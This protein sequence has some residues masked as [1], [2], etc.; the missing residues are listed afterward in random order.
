MFEGDPG[1]TMYEFIDGLRYTYYCAQDSGCDA[2]YWNSLDT[3]DALPTVNPYTVD[4][5]TISIDLHFG[6][7]LP[8]LWTLDAM[9]S[10]LTFI[11]M[12]R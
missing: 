9:A 3:S 6:I 1:N 11:M 5:N 8:T 10:W 12:R 7:W 4:D 2:T